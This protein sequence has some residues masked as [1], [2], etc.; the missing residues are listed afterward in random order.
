M[1]EIVTV[2]LDFEFREYLNKLKSGA[3]LY[4]RDLLVFLW[5]CQ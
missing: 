3:T 2:G 5:K 4:I 1:S